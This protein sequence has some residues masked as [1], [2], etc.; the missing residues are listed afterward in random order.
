MK[1]TLALILVTLSLPA[2]ASSADDFT[3]AQ[4]QAVVNHFNQDAA[5]TFIGK[6]TDFTLV[7]GKFYT[8]GN[9][10]CRDGLIITNSYDT[11][12]TACKAGGDLHFYFDKD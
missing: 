2:L 6:N 10:R 9:K 4:K 12:F 3:E 5:K 1:T 7:Y 8:N 11:G